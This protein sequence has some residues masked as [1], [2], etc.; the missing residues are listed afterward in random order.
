MGSSKLLSVSM[1]V[2]AALAGRAIAGEMTLFEGPELSGRH[3]TVHGEIPNFD[4][5]S[6]NDRAESIVVSSGYWEVCTD[7]YFRGECTRLGPG[8]YR[9]LGRV[10]KDAISSVRE[11]AD[12]GRPPPE[13]RAAPP[14]DR[15]AP[16]RIDFYDR[17]DFGGRVITLTS[18]NNNFED[19]GFND[20]ADSVIVYAGIWR[21]CVDAYMEGECRDFGPGRYDEIG[22][23]GGKVSS[24]AVVGGA[25]VES[26]N[27]PGPP[28]TAPR[29]NV[30]PRVIVYEFP[31]FGGRSMLIESNELSN[32]D[33]TD[34]NDRTAS[35]RV[36]AGD[37]VFCSDAYFQGTC[38]T[39][40]PGDYRSL[41][42][43]LDRKISSARLVSGG[44]YAPR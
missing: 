31:D 6:F 2:A 17:R 23:L 27:R 43:D 33:Q 4:R 37:W 36:E 10:L 38:R 7:A 30:R 18:S 12:A 24:A 42:W 22:R 9:H 14:V 16:P 19:I 20:R 1:L 41:A 44:S 26:G 15:S 39:F 28:P 13:Y 21:L 35:I 3:I 5:G 25:I 40:G 32:F 29:P 8:E 11:L 34:F